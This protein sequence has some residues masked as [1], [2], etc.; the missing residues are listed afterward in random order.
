MDA[1]FYESFEQGNR[2]LSVAKEILCHTFI[3]T[4]DME[5]DVSENTDLVFSTPFGSVEFSVRIRTYRWF[6]DAHKYEF[7]LCCHRN[8][9]YP[10]E[11]QK[12]FGN[13][14]DGKEHGHYMFYGFEDESGQDIIWWFIG[15][16]SV[17]REWWRSSETSFICTSDNDRYLGNLMRNGEKAGECKKVA[18][19][20]RDTGKKY[21]DYMYIF[22]RRIIPGFVIASSEDAEWI[23][24]KTWTRK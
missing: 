8:S 6:K 4:A 7:T 18:R 22:D 16:L 10:A 15:D 13:G 19:R 9:R 11:W 12:I 17:F 3:D 14:A 2:T 21:Y 5:Q 1:T 23:E 20:D 24:R